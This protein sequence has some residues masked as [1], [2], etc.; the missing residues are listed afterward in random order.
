MHLMFLFRTV[1]LSFS[2]SIG[3]LERCDDASTISKMHWFCAHFH[4][5]VLLWILAKQ[6]RGKPR[7][8]PCFLLCWNHHLAARYA[9]SEYQRCPFQPCRP[10]LILLLA[11][12]KSFFEKNGSY[13]SPLSLSRLCWLW[14]QQYDEALLLRLHYDHV[15][16]RCHVHVYDVRR[17]AQYWLSRFYGHI[18]SQPRR[19]NLRSR[20]LL[21]WA[22]LWPEHGQGRLQKTW[23]PLGIFL[24]YRR[25]PELDSRNML[26]RGQGG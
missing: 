10:P 4:S 22:L 20:Q 2:R 6:K 8:A 17:T 24:W 7:W 3:F 16:R 12:D 19:S 14:Y 23:R 13:I 5:F 26:S 15:G 25:L 9:G 21:L 1:G 11:W 18:G